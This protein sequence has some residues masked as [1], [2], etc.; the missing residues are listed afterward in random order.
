ME[1]PLL[2]LGIAKSKVEVKKL[3]DAIDEDKSGQIEFDEFLQ[4][5]KGTSKIHGEPP[6]QSQSNEAIMKFFKSM[7]VTDLDM[8]EGKI[9][10]NSSNLAFKMILSQIRRDRLMKLCMSYKS[11]ESGSILKDEITTPYSKIVKGIKPDAQFDYKTSER[12]NKTA[13]TANPKSEVSK[14]NSSHRH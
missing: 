9:E 1:E 11:G 8:V 4:I 2:T 6:E 13:I 14:S 3:M 12:S 10:G 7:I 5:L